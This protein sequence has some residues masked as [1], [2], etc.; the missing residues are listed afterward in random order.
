M[1]KATVSHGLD[2]YGDDYPLMYSE[3]K[4]RRKV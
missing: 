3:M 1:R 4:M 2:F